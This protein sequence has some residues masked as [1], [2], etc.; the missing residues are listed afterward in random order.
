MYIYIYILNKI[1]HPSTTTTTTITNTHLTITHAYTRYIYKSTRIQQT[2]MIKEQD[3]NILI[4][5]YQH[6]NTKQNG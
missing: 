2:H 6:L 1:K 3:N 4:V 5:D